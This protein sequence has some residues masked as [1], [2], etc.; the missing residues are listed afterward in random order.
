MFGFVYLHHNWGLT[1]AIKAINRISYGFNRFLRAYESIFPKP[2]FSKLSSQPANPPPSAPPKS[3]KFKDQRSYLHAVN[4]TR[5]KEVVIPDGSRWLHN[6]AMVSCKVASN[7][8]LIKSIL[9]ELE[10]FHDGVSLLGDTRAL[11]SFASKDLL[12]SFLDKK[13]SVQDFFQHGRTLDC[14]NPIFAEI[15]LG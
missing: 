9:K 4:N 3:F 5:V 14:Q 11:V 7:V 13:D 8:L 15:H 10:V 6:S 12:N 1:L 2:S